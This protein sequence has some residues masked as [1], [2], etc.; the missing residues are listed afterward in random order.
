MADI[1]FAIDKGVGVITLERCKVLNALNFAMLAALYEQLLR[2]QDQPEVKRVVIRS[3]C[4]RAFCAGGD[5]RSI[6]N[7]GRE[8]SLQSRELFKL[9]YQLNALIGTYK[10]PYIALLDGLTMG[11]GVGISMHGSHP[12]AT[13]NFQFA[14][15]ETG[16]GFFPDIGSSYL[17]QRCP[18]A[19]AMYLA[20]TGITINLVD[21]VYAKLIRYHVNSA[22]INQPWPA[23]LNQATKL[24]LKQAN[25]AKQ[26]ELI[27][28]HFA[29]PSLDAIFGSLQNDPE[30]WAQ[31]T[32]KQLQ[33]KSPTS[34]VV[35]FA[36]IQHT[37]KLSLRDCLS[38]DFQLSQYFLDQH[39]FYEGIRAAII[40]K[41][42]QPRWQKASPIAPCLTELMC[43]AK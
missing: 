11:G 7:H 8:N 13:E 4:A 3:S 26:R 28:K 32:L 22:H 36:Q 6:Y 9:E 1:C 23:L 12:I 18:G 2:W 16:I 5:I 30:P 17:F 25:L 19:I 24:D 42:K 39:D 37:R 14:M 38:L 35:T 20:L 27:D 43:K 33:S 10:K 31:A 15:P 21:A 41:D 29:E 40:D 34:L